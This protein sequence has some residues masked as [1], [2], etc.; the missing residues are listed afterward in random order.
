MRSSQ[1]TPQPVQV[2]S[3]ANV[4]K[5]KGILCKYAEYLRRKYQTEIPSVSL[6]WPPPPTCK[7]FNLAMIKQETK[8]LRDEECSRL[9][10]RG[11]VAGV[12]RK[13]AE[14][15]LED[16]VKPDKKRNVILIEG[17]PGAGKST[18][19]WHICQKWGAGEL[20]QEFVMII[21]MQL[22]DLAIQSATTLANILSETDRGPKPE[23][24]ISAIKDCNGKH[25]LFVLDGWDEFPPGFHKASIIEGLI[26]TPANFSMSSR[27]LIITSRPIATAE[28]RR[29]ASSRVEI[30]GF[31]QTEMKRYFTEALCEPQIVQKLEDHLKL[32]PVIEASCYLPLNAAIVVHIFLAL[33]YSLP[34]TLHG[35]FT[36]LVLCCITRHLTRQA[37]EGEEIPDISSLNDLPVDTQEPFNNICTLA[38][39]GAR[40]NKPTFSKADLQSY[41][42]PTE[43]STLSL[44]QAV[45]SFTVL[46][47][48][49]SYSFLH[50]S[51]QEL[52]AAFHISKMSPEEQVKIFDELFEEPRF[53]AVFQF[54]AAFTK[55]QSEG[56]RNV[57]TRIV[58]RK[59][60][61][62]L[63]SLLRCLYE[64]RDE[65][66]CKF[67]AL[68]LN[69]ELNLFGESVSPVD[70]LSVGYFLNSVCL[71]TSG[72]F[73]VILNSCRLN[74]YT[75]S[76]LCKELFE[77]SGTPAVGA[78]VE[79]HLHLR[80]DMLI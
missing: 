27:T 72:E 2:Y 77:C 3:E 69:G 40:E 45:N 36:S 6:Q 57:V 33:N 60:K 58:Q 10:L 29:F 9:L 54:Y 28:L 23:E 11:D 4:P 63:L 61:L 64:T 79:G 34:T 50:L 24:V 37:G 30:V 7:V 71:N 68:Q 53:A 56:V 44:I 52:L 25:V 26:C 15:K 18:L 74:E 62:L 49:K 13:K 47:K 14:V 42:L 59:S 39:H 70:C 78:G 21:F 75:I 16:I 1:Q 8:Y 17:A 20:F 32:R 48:S 46:G 31:Q 5:S 19:A 73:N 22:R 35:V 67:V 12:M 76:L 43:L 66:L 41:H 55:L 51:V 80:Y 65:S 38:Y